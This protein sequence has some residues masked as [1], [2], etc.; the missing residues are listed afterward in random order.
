MGN[1]V[2][3]IEGTGSHHNGNAATDANEKAKEF[4]HELL[5]IGQNV[6]AATFT[7]GSRESVMVGKREA[8]SE[9]G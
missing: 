2:I 5:G 4:V 9:G 8:T 7:C 3:H 6:E 1:W